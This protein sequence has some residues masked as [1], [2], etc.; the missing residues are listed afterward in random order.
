MNS[1][2]YLKATDFDRA[3][4]NF[5][6]D[7]PLKP[8]PN[9]KTNPFYINRPGNPINELIDALLAPFYRPPKF[10]FSG[11]RGCGKSTEL[12]H[13]LSNADIQK[14]YWPI[15]FSIREETD[16]IDLD[17]RDV[18]LAIGSRLFR[19]YRKK[20]G[21]LPDQLLKELNGWK[22][23]VEKQI[24]TILDGRVSEYELGASIDAFFAHAGLK[25]KLEPATR[26]ELRQIVETDI[27]GLI[28]IINHIAAAIYN[29]ERRIPLILIDDMDKPDLDRARA[30]FHDRREI[31]MQPNCAIVY[32]VSSA[33]F[34]SKEFDAIRDQAL[35]LPN[36]NLRTAT[37]AEQQLKEGYRTLE[38]FVGV[39]MS[40][41]LIHASALEEAI[42]YSGGVFRELARIIRTSIGRARRRKAAQL[43][44][45]DVEW[46]VTEIRNEYRRILDK[47]DIK[48]LKKIM[49]SKRLEFSDRLRPLMQL[50]A[51][52]E[53]RDQENW[54]DVH[55]VLRKML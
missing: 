44:I 37:D 54:C 12:L 30:I 34:Y 42:T 41:A 8:G 25:M 22:G 15:N 27:T 3:W 43:E 23:K 14:K 32:T 40:P 20:G 17:Y 29:Q 4:M 47:E 6:L 55:P 9:G 48:L 51:I 38:K 10:F 50:L 1:F 31:M 53:Y 39:R 21:E 5:E 24:S 52:L 26:V 36:I 49:E 7:L 16:I 33:L 19:E 11:H 2:D 45:E 13:L 35:F 18:L 28:A 46:A